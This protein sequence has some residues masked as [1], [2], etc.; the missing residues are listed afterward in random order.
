MLQHASFTFKHQALYSGT[1]LASELP[2]TH[3]LVGHIL[4]LSCSGV[5]ISPHLILADLFFCIHSNNVSCKQIRWG[6]SDTSVAK[7]LPYEQKERAWRAFLLSSMRRKQQ[8][9]A[10]SA[11]VEHLPI[12]QFTSASQMNL[13]IP[14]Y[15]EGPLQASPPLWAGSSHL[16]SSR[17][18]VQI[19]WGFLPQKD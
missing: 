4:H 13:E 15:R 7:E 12:L 11:W 16:W 5:Y 17:R 14:G 2:V 8:T 9:E 19:P 10:S 1:S 6:K 3:R 18:D